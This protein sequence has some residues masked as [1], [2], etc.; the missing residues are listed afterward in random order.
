MCFYQ[1][2]KRVLSTFF[3]IQLRSHLQVIPTSSLK[4]VVLAMLRFINLE[5]HSVPSLLLSLEVSNTALAQKLFAIGSR[6]F[7]LQ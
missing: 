3:G 5:R 6:R 2:A 4:T 1:R 7:A